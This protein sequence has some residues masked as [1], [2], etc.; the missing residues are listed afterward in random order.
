MDLVA[1]LAL[2]SDKR[3]S[4]T[5]QLSMSIH[6]DNTACLRNQK[7][8]GSTIDHVC[9]EKIDMFES[10]REKVGC[11]LAVHTEFYCLAQ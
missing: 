3:S 11:A 2:I 8:I 9:D 7:S 10:K 4:T 5:G 6:F 1:A